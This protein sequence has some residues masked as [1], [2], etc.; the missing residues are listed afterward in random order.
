MT[1]KASYAMMVEMTANTLAAMK[2]IRINAAVL[3]A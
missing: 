3:G 2:D 1:K